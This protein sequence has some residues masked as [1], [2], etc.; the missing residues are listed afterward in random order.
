[1]E[2]NSEHNTV[3]RTIRMGRCPWFPDEWIPIF[4]GMQITQMIDIIASC[5]KPWYHLCNL[6][7]C[8]KLGIK[9]I[10][11]SG[12]QE[13]YIINNFQYTISYGAFT[14]M[15]G[16]PPNHLLK[17]RFFRCKPSSYGLRHERPRSRPSSAP[18]LRRL[19]FVGVEGKENDPES[20]TDVSENLF[21]RNQRYENF[22]TFWKC[23]L[24]D[25][26]FTIEDF[27]LLP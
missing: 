20:M 12:D 26:I 24:Y 4:Y 14:K 16:V 11:I 3:Q 10:K 23:I 2:V 15:G 27:G 6:T 5:H 8:P 9:S 1:M 25:S 7:S 17:N 18:N 19:F 22:G 21:S 13:T